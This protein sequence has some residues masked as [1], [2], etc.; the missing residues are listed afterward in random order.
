MGEESEKKRIENAEQTEN[1]RQTFEERIA[2]NIHES[3]RG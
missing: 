1:I 3:A 2:S